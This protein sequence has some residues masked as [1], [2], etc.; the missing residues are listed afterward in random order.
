MSTPDLRLTSTS[1][2]IL[3]M[4]QM[5]GACTTYELGK[6][7]Q[8]TFDYFWPRARSLI[9]AE[10]KRLAALG[11]LDAQKDYV[12]KRPRTTYASTEAGREALA[13]WLDTPPRT[14]ALEFEGLVRVYLAPFGS[15]DNLLQALEAVAEQAETMLQVG[16]GFRRGYLEGT[17]PFMDQVHVRALLN[18]FLLNYVDLVRRWSERSIETVRSWED[19][20]PAGKQE[21]AL[22]TIAGLPAREE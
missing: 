20:T 11:L 5:L 14:F 2:A 1:Y 15:R 19:L 8:G 18:D 17:S 12:G 9:Y 3:G 16:A 7:M 6:A 22:R 10:V 21:N 13:S 4:V